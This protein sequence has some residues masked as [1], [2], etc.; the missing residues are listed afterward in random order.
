VPH[1]PNQSGTFRGVGQTETSLC[2][3]SV[4]VSCSQTGR[5]STVCNQ[6]ECFRFSF[7]AGFGELVFDEEAFTRAQHEAHNPNRY[8]CLQALREV[9]GAPPK[10]IKLA[11]TKKRALESRCYDLRTT[12]LPG[13]RLYFSKESAV[14]FA[15][16][17]I[18]KSVFERVRGGAADITE[19]AHCDLLFTDDMWGI[20]IQGLV[21]SKDVKRTSAYLSVEV[22]PFLPNFCPFKHQKKGE[23]GL[24]S[25]TF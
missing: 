1:L 12:A 10:V 13:D 2:A 8:L 5:S 9:A 4:I 24:L 21:A 20:V 16:L 25:K 17:Q 19:G 7:F 23:P 11:F 18:N 3:C 6:I 15:I 22:S 14:E